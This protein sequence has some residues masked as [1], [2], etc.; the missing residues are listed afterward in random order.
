MV[1][2]VNRSRLAISV[3]SLQSKF[4]RY[5]TGGPVVRLIRNVA[6]IATSTHIPGV[7]P[8][9]WQHFVRR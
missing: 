9:G 3:E 8:R 4:E 6:Q 5:D 1:V 7:R 2:A